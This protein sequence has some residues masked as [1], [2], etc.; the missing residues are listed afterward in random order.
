MM[1][2]CNIELGLAIIGMSVSAAVMGTG[3]IY[4]FTQRKKAKDLL[5]REIVELEDK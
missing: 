1:N 2:L 5:E 3:L 4:F